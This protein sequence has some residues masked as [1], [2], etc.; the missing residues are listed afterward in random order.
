MPT[1]V[2]YDPEDP[3]W[4]PEET[5]D[6]TARRLAREVDDLREKLQREHVMHLQA[7]STAETYQRMAHRAQ[8]NLLKMAAAS[9]ALVLLVALASRLQRSA[10]A[11]QTATPGV[12]PG[13]IREPVPSAPPMAPGVATSD[14]S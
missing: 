12:A 3:D 13:G 1:E 11:P 4:E 7:R 5:A 6:P 10:S 8:A 14:E 2:L 9:L